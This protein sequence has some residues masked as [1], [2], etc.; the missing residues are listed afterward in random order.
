[1]ENR[2]LVYDENGNFR[3][4]DTTNY[5]DDYII[6]TIFFDRNVIEE[7]KHFCVILGYG[8][9]EKSTGYFYPIDIHDGAVVMFEGTYNCLSEQL[10]EQM[11]KYNLHKPITPCWSYFFFEW[12]FQLSQDC[13]K[14]NGPMIELCSE[15]L[16]K[17]EI[18]ELLIKD[19]CHIF[20]PKDYNELKIITK[21]LFDIFK[22]NINEMDYD[23][24][25]KYLVDSVLNGYYIRFEERDIEK[26]FFNVCNFCVKRIRGEI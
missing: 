5:N 8:L 11:I 26:F 14:K 4:L 17:K 23:I 20:E 18:L 2:I 1:M 21:K 13:F 25:F 7:I 22:I 9:I 19:D 24:K 3:E 15:C 10:K 6:G 12:Q 16:A